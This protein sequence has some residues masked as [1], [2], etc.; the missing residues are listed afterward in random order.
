MVITT[1]LISSPYLEVSFIFSSDVDVPHWLNTY[2]HLLSNTGDVTLGVYTDSS[3]L[4]EA[5]YSFDDYQNANDGSLT[6]SGSYGA[7]DTFNANMDVYKTC[8]PCRAYNREKTYGRQLTE[9]NDGQGDYESNNYNC[10]DDADYLNCNQC[11]KV[12]S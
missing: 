11:Y 12:S 10:F 6:A 5:E 7:F 3:C 4:E 2:L 9:Y 1:T 8:Q